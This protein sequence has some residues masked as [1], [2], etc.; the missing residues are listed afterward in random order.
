M[1]CE[2]CK[3][4]VV[5]CNCPVTPM[6]AMEYELQ[7]LR[8]RKQMLQE[9]LKQVTNIVHRHKLMKW[10]VEVSTK[11]GMYDETG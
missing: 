3:A 6:N 7:D 2:K 11:I 1:N 4:S 5:L 10:I 8:C 9:Q